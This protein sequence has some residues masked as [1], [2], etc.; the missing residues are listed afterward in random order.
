MAFNLRLERLRRMMRG[1]KDEGDR[2]RLRHAGIADA[3]KT[4]YQTP[5]GEIVF[6]DLLRKGDLLSATNDP[7]EV[8][9]RQVA[10][11]I[12]NMLGWSE[13]E[14]LR[15]HQ[16]QTDDVMRDAVFAQESAA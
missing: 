10:L 11:H 3:Y 6:N 16:Q 12:L 2:Q 7:N 14:L 1:T 13:A 9:R 4:M 5:E 8:G 15:F